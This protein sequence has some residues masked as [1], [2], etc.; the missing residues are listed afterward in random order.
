MEILITG[1]DG[2]IGQN[3]KEYFQQKG[4]NVFGTV[5]IRDAEENEV[6]FDIRDEKEFE[7]LPNR[8]F[9]VIIHTAGIVDQTVPK[10]QMFL[11]NAEGTKKMVDW[12]ESNGCRHFIQL[13]SVSVYG[14]K[15][16]GENRTEDRTKRYDGVLAIPYQRSKAKAERYIE[17]SKLNYTM[18]RLPAVLGENDTYVSPSIIPRLQNG[19]FYFCGTKDKLFSTLY[20]K[21][22]PLFIDKI[23]DTGPLNDVFNCADHHMTW[24]EYVGEY[25]TLLDV[26]PGNKKK[27]I[28][29]VL[30][31]I[32]DKK[33]ALIMTFSRF[34]GHY[35]SDKLIERLG[36]NPVK[37]TWQEGVKE[38]VKGFVAAS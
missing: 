7:K 13:S 36:C 38:A 35:P 30:T 37:H 12:A 32:N 16:N 8:A 3:I 23:I 1:T 18:L 14:L 31:R 26:D 34:G 20:V 28:V 4:C 25:A 5:F 15:T 22:L 10:K 6:R 17:K 29:T 19:T 24:R 9:D 2:F 21:N 27:S 33:W 11:V